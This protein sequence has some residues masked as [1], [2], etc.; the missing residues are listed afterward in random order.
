MGRGGNTCNI[1][2]C[3]VLTVPHKKEERKKKQSRFFFAS[4]FIWIFKG[5]SLNSVCEYLHSR[6]TVIFI[7]HH[8][9]LQSYKV[10]YTIE[11]FDR[12]R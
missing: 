3:Y 5:I 1:F 12:G 11:Q 4:S 10:L 8:S 6:D 2:Y 7:N 9:E